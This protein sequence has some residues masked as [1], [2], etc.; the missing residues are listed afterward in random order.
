MMGGDQS[1]FPFFV[2]PAHHEKDRKDKKRQMGHKGQIG[3]EGYR[4]KGLLLLPCLMSAEN[5]E[6]DGAHGPV[7]K[8]RKAGGVALA[9]LSFGMSNNAME[10]LFLHML[11]ENRFG[12][13]CC[14]FCSAGCGF[15][16]G[17]GGFCLGNGGFTLLL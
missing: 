5:S 7:R 4:G 10:K 9:G 17:S 8:K 6:S 15:C 12:F 2:V 3:R 14:G 1:I 16:S 11:H 13:V